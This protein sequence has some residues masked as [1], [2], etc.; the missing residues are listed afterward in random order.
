VKLKATKLYVYRTN[1]KHNQR[2]KSPI[3]ISICL[4]TSIE[5]FI[6]KQQS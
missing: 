5:G 3:L 1:N 4:R 2:N 6:I